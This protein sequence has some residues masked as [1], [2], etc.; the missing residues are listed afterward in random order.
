MSLQN[1]S[2]SFRF[3]G[4]FLRDPLSVGSLVPSSAFLSR[5]MAVA[6][7]EKLNN[8]DCVIEIG[9]GTGSLTRALLKEGVAHDRLICLE[10]DVNMV[11]CL[12]K[13][14]P[15]LTIIHGNACFLKDALAFLK[16][17][18]GAIVSGLPMRNFSAIV[19]EKILQESFE[20]M[21]DVGL[22]YQF[23]Y[24]YVSPLK[25]LGF[26]GEKVDFV[27]CNFPPAS[28]WRYRRSDDV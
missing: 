28:I 12:R 26:Q 17:R 14:F 22:F 7:V 19:R 2:D 25:D 27:W 9:A 18:V 16:R 15:D 5:A 1:F 21:Q 3:M 24:G 4:R 11:K 10:S 23:T 20:L 6:V 8:M 13:K